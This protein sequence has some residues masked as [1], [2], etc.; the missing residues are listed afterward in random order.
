[1]ADSAKCL[2]Q[3][4]ATATPGGTDWS[5]V[6]SIYTVPDRASAVISSIVLCEG[7]NGT[8]ILFQVGLFMDSTLMSSLVI[9]KNLLF[10]DQGIGAK[11]TKIIS[12]GITMDERNVLAIT[13]SGTVGVN[14]FGVETR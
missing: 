4:T 12:A 5:S 6:T 8:G 3:A 14:V 11:E 13:S 7:A 9:G 2:L 10:Y 1:M